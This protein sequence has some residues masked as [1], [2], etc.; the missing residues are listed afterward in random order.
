VSALYSG[1]NL[2]VLRRHIP[3]A[4]ADAVEPQ[5]EHAMEKVRRMSFAVL[6]ACAV[7]LAVSACDGTPTRPTP[8]T[9]YI[10]SATLVP[11]YELSG[12]YSWTLTGPSGF[13]CSMGTS[14][15]VLCPPV[16]YTAGTSVTLTVT[17]LNPAF[18]DV[19]IINGQGCD[20]I[21]RL[22]CTVTMDDN[23]TVSIQVS[24]PI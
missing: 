10:L 23:R 20:S 19:R 1:G 5:G 2:D 9:T 3:D 22:T 11:G 8:P 16:S 18:E 6:C 13:A 12:P 4:S 15:N 7:G 17:N 24:G 14:H 21:T